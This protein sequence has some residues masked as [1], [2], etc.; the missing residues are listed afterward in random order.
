[1]S[2]L[3]C[4]DLNTDKCTNPSD[5]ILK[6]CMSAFN[7]IPQL[8]NLCSTCNISGFFNKKNYFD[9]L[10]GPCYDFFNFA[11]IK[12]PIEYEQ[13]K[14]FMY[15]FFRI[16]KSF[17]CNFDDSPDNIGYLEIKNELLYICKNYGICGYGLNCKNSN[18]CNE[19][20]PDFGGIC[21]GLNYNSLNNENKSLIDFCSC[22]L[23]S[24]QYINNNIECDGLCL[25]NTVVKSFDNF[26]NIKNCS[27]NICNISDISINI[28][29]S[30]NTKVNFS[31]LCGN[32]VNGICSRCI[33]K[34]VSINKLNTSVDVNI[35]S[36][37][38]SEG[39]INGFECYETENGVIKKIECKYDGEI[40]TVNKDNKYG[41]YIIITI[42]IIFSILIILYIILGIVNYK[43]NKKYLKIIK[44]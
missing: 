9:I 33:L 19:N 25:Q 41:F 13:M 7:E 1:M 20:Y 2:C 15:D 38:N 44:K 26:S 3:Y 35:F 42:I 36:S 18:N 28:L 6:A 11:D 34:D 22:Y 4:N 30:S 24:D 5:D 12:N 8:M 21:S 37:C 16:L 10:P 23:D 43:N 17:N 29:E 31:Q 40:P 32:C 27:S 14:K 39:N